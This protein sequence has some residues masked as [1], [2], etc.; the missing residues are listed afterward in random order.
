[1]LPWKLLHAFMP[2]KLLLLLLHAF[3]HK[4]SRSPC[5]QSACHNSCPAQAGQAKLCR[6]TTTT[7]LKYFAPHVTGAKY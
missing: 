3:M 4:H 7:R 5:T 1:M 6:T 2:W